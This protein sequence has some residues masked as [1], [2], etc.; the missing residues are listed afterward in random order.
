M[1]SSVAACGWIG[2]TRRGEDPSKNFQIGAGPQG[3]IRTVWVG[4]RPARWWLPGGIMFRVPRVVFGPRS[5]P[6][7]I[8]PGPPSPLRPARR[9]R[10]QGF[11]DGSGSGSAAAG[12]G[13]KRLPSRS[14]A[15]R[16]PREQTRGLAQRPAR[17]RPLR[18]PGPATPK[19]SAPV[20]TAG[21]SAGASSS[22]RAAAPV[23]VRQWFEPE[24]NQ[25]PPSESPLI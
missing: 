24:R 10:G 9:L 2:H 13:V 11:R 3:L 21:K 14:R 19:G 25:T 1:C 6:R 23:V 16:R 7:S 18:E 20:G 5:P 4:I 17:I 8:G 12:G 22:G 15:F